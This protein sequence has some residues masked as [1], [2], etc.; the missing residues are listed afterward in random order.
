METWLQIL[1]IASI[2]LVF[3]T[4]SL[5]WLIYKETNRK[6]GEDGLQGQRGQQGRVGLDGISGNQ[7]VQ[8]NQGDRVQ[9]E[10]GERGEQGMV[11]P[12]GNPPYAIFFDENVITQSHLNVE[13]NATARIYGY[14]YPTSNTAFLTLTGQFT[15]T[16]LTFLRAFAVR[17]PQ[18]ILSLGQNLQT[19]GLPVPGIRSPPDG[20]INVDEGFGSSILSLPD[21]QNNKNITIILGEQ[22]NFLTAN[23]QYFVRI[24]LKAP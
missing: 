13:T 19:V 9:G 1:I 2:A 23:S 15:T 4:A 6:K 21:T 8:G 18:N 14:Y 7:G 22:E 11:G 5:T 10:K 24:I 17:I 3:A 12:P 16:S 20:S